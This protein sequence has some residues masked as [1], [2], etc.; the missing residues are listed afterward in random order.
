MFTQYYTYDDVLIKPKYSE[1]VSRKKVKLSSRLTDNITLKV[2]IIS[3]NMD[4][5]TEDRMAIAIAKCGGMGII[6]RYCSIEEQ[7]SMVKRVKRYT[8]HIIRRPQSINENVSISDAID[9]I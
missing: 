6:H 8:N 9:V 2:P 5:I 3:S 7:C 1:I 4:T